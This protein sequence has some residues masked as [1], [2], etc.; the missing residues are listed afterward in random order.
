[1]DRGWTTVVVAATGPSFSQAQ[2][3]AIGA[4]RAADRCRVIAIN[5]A[6][7]Q[8]PHADVLY[9]G[10]GRWYDVHLPAIRAA[11]FTGEMWTQNKRAMPGYFPSVG[12]PPGPP[13]LS[14][15]HY[16]EGKSNPGLTKRPYVIHNGR[17]SGFAAINL[18]YLFGG[19]RPMRIIVVG[20]DM[21]K[22]KDG[23]QHFFGDHPKPLSNDLP[24]EVCIEHFG[25]L[26][27]DLE[28][29]GVTVI[30]A[31][32]DTALTCFKRDTL[33]RAIA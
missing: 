19:M 27:M 23:R 5:D 13:P 7:R 9:A 22:G 16:V 4:A 10:D 11:R 2:A 21:Q 12:P 32:A 25:V 18:A 28:R 14:G 30:N 20:L 8:L 29:A 31:T 24:F 6:W 15:C 17:N 33:E 1:M 3:D 26:A